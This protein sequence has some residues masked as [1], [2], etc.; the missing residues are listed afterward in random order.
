[1]EYN[2]LEK[3]ELWITG[4]RLHRVNL[5]ELAARAAQVLGL[6]PAEVK[7]VDVREGVVTLDLLRQTVRA[8]DIA[9]K[10]RV[11]LRELAAVPGVELAP[12][13][14][15]H[16]DGVLGLIALDP[17][18]AAE[19]LSRTEEMTAS[20][21]EAVSRRA[22]VYSTGFEVQRG[23]IEDTNG[24]FIREALEGLGFRVTLGP[25]LEDSEHAIA[26][27]FEEAVSRGYGLAITTGGVGAESKD[28]SVEGLLRVDPDAA[29]AWLV[30]YPK[31]QGRHEK[32]G[33]R[34][35]VGRVGPTLLVTLPGPHDEVRTAMPVLCRHLASGPVD[36][37]ALVEDLAAALRAA[38]GGGA[39]WAHANP[40]P[41]APEG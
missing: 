8:E 3:T 15:V 28:R 20:I 34:I 14:A 32:E 16:S 36:K 18:E 33:V 39:H 41:H 19:V 10:E 1:M 38:M 9:G 25:V 12:D 37:R 21:L 31:G 29:T 4:I 5:T 26:R 30:H 6:G 40:H 27:A 24:P 22:I 17:A 13:A 11:L 23:L 7:V 35:A 2:L